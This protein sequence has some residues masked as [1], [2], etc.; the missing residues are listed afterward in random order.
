MYI[1]LDYKSSNWSTV[2]K[3]LNGSTIVI[4]KQMLFT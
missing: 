3:A 2:D 4:K 1:M